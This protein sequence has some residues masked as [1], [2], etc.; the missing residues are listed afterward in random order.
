MIISATMTPV[1][2]CFGPI[3]FTGSISESLTHISEI[4]YHGVELHI[5]TPHHLDIEEFFYLLSKHGLTLTSIGTGL[6]YA[7][8]GLSFGSDDKIIR[9]KAVQRIKDIID[10]FA[11]SKPVIIIG[12]MKGKL[13]AAKNKE[14]AKSRIRE[15]LHECAVYADR[16]GMIIALEAINRYEQDYLNTLA[17]S[18]ELI[19]S[20]G[21]SNIK[22]HADIFH[23]N[24]EEMSISGA[25]YAFKDY[26]GHLHFADNNR[27]S[28]GQ[29]G[30]DF[31]DILLALKNIGYEGSIGIECMP[32]PDG[33]SAAIRGYRYLSTVAE[34]IDIS[35]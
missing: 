18:A 8:E 4:G 26:L 5:S 31:K 22:V 24:I 6:S 20:I 35:L 30:I 2:S 15:A 17:E 25:I 33:K 1:P 9:D 32:K 34:Q 16:S 28:P 19:D 27:L 29:G 14:I 21:A 11:A 23:M 13:S 12:T 10:L 7:D 3:L